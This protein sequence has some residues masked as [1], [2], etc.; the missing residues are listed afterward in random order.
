MFVL[1]MFIESL[2]NVGE[3]DLQMWP[4]LSS[5]LP[6]RILEIPLIQDPNIQVLN[7]VVGQILAV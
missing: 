1:E 2:P 6:K 3:L 7:L 4:S 5:L